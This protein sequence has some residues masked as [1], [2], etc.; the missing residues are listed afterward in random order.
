MRTRSSLSLRTDQFLG[1]WLFSVAAFGRGSDESEYLRACPSL[2]GTCERLGWDYS[3]L[4]D[5]RDNVLPALSD[6]WRDEYDWSAF[7]AVGFTSTFEQ[8]TAAFALARRIKEKHPKV[9]NLFGGANFDGDMGR[10][11][12]RGLGFI[13]YVVSGEADEIL[14]RVV[15]RIAAGASPLGLPGVSGRKEQAVIDGGTTR[16]FTI[17]TRCRLPTTTSIL[18]RSSGWGASAFWAI[19]RRCC[20]SKARADAGGARSTT[21]RFAG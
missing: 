11:Y 19:R 8:N 1:E 9:T 3:R 20:F 5:L 12:V 14:P 21:A 16:R 7:D 2:A 4:C 10:E 17:W 13:D 15:S 6:R 18:R